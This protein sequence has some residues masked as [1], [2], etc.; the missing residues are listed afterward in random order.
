VLCLLAGWLDV[1]VVVVLLVV[2]SR[3][4]HGARFLYFARLSPH[5]PR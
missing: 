1:V 4:T 5:S 2:H 3:L